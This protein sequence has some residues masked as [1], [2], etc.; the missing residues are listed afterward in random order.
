MTYLA[1]KKETT[2]VVQLFILSC[3]RI[4][5][6]RETVASA[7]A[8]TYENY[9]IIVSDNSEREDVADMLAREFP[10][11]GV[12][13]RRPPLPA[14]D[15]FNKLIDEAVAPLMVLFHDDDVLEPQYISRMVALLELYPEVAA[16]GCNA[17]L[18]KGNRLTQHPFMGDYKGAHLL[19]KPIDLLEP[20]LSLSLISPAP[21]PGYMYR[22]N[23]IKGLGL[24]F[25][26]G[27]KH[28]DVSFLTS[29]FARAPILWTDECLFRYRFHESNDS[30]Q[31]S[32]ANRLTWLR[33]IYRTTGIVPKS[34][35]IVDYKF[36]YWWR[37][38]QQSVNI[39]ANSHSLTVFLRRRHLVGLKFVLCHGLYM[40]LT[41][42][43]FWRR[44]WRVISK[45]LL[46]LF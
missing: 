16:V 40:A 25:D 35:S 8:Q 11:V 22:T 4:D 18:L 19:P 2:T 43:T 45:K 44:A 5:F 21:F 41:R 12:I 14:L 3:D 9:Q 24:T 10:S 38:L 37:W 6:C 28:A 17:R 42:L 23:A 33:H 34:N 15:H 27:G 13:R 7:I 39:G 29:I 31:E 1:Q 46:S 30:S 26:S 20:Y 32:I 36:L